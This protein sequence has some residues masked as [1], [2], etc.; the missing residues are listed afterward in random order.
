MINYS[1]EAYNDGY[2]FSDLSLE[3]QTMSKNLYVSA[4]VMSDLSYS[5]TTYENMQNGGEKNTTEFV[6]D[7]IFPTSGI[8]YGFIVGANAHPIKRNEYIINLLINEIEIRNIKF[9]TYGNDVVWKAITETCDSDFCIN[10]LMGSLIRV[11]VFNGVSGNGA[12]YSYIQ[13]FEFFSDEEID[14]L[15][16]IINIMIKQTE[17][18]D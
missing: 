17:G 4:E 8:Y 15:Y 1:I 5:M 6:R 9:R 14:T 2:D 10:D 16:K 13:K 18:N 11:K 7:W 3:E 12:K